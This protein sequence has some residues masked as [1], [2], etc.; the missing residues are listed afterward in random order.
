MKL[1]IKFVSTCNLFYI[2]VREIL[3]KKE[4][5]QINTQTT[6]NKTKNKP[7]EDIFDITSDKIKYLINISILPTTLNIRMKSH[8]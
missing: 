8:P 6:I 1:K 4:M 7:S 2:T 5:G 3:K